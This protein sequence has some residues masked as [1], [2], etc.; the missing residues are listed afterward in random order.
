M[1]KREDN[2]TSLDK[3]IDNYC[4]KLNTP[5]RIAFEEGYKKFKKTLTKK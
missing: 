4:G 2:I 1:K 3:F 5:E